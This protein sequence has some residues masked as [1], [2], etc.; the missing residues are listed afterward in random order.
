M[1]ILITGGL[2][3]VGRHLSHLLLGRGHRV[4]AVGT[5]RDPE[6]IPHAHF[7]YISADTSREGPW[8]EA[9][10]GVDAVV[11]LAGKPIFTRWT[12][13]A[14]KLIYESRIMT[15][16]NLVAS[17][18]GNEAITLCSASGVG[19]YGNRGDEILEENDP[20]GDDFLSGVARDWEAEAFRAEEKGIRVAVARLG[21]VL[22][23]GG[24]AMAKMIPVFRSLAGG[25]LGDGRQWFPWIHLDDTLAA[26]LFVLENAQIKGALNFTA[27]HPVRNREFAAALGKT[28][29][30][31]AI[32]PAPAFMVRLMMG[33]FGSA[34]LAS[35]R[36]VPAKLLHA[37]FKFQY[38]R[39]A[40]ALQNIIRH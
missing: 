1:N 34:L 22:G 19:Y 10:Q 36:A 38:P 26:F 23:K 18:A 27:P 13:R 15:T 14:K 20:S 7:H 30:R 39:M 12:R 35:Q 11:N 5:R 9:L 3:F 32:M 31:P 2:G 37:G 24:G 25:P 40:T 4:T 28:L 17:L 21:I 8:Q 16:R 29:N 6:R 33:E